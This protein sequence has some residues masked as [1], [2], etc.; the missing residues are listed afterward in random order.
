[1]KQEDL[2]NYC[3]YE[4]EITLTTSQKIYGVLNYD[5]HTGTFF[6][7]GSDIHISASMVESVSILKS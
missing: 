1:M 2:F 3:G 6:L 5:K 4:V 7:S